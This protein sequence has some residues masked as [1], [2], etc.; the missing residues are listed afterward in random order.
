MQIININLVQGSGAGENNVRLFVLDGTLGQADQVC[1][2]ADSAA[3]H[4]THRDHLAIGQGG[5]AG[6]LAGALQIFHADA[7]LVSTAA[8]GEWRERIGN[9]PSCMP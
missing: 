3:R 7:L 1:T 8:R 5:L 6:D 9:S 4:Q 2:N